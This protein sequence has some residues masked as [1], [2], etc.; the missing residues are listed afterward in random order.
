MG[1]NHDDEVGGGEPE[2]S[3]NGEDVLHRRAGH[4]NENANSWQVWFE[5]E[6][7]GRE[8]G[9]LILF[10]CNDEAVAMMN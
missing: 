7:G 10:G 9:I 6:P 2:A 3:C 8:S 1:A 5:D 4:S